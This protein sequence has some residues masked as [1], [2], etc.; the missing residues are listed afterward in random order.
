VSFLRK[1]ADSLKRQ[2]L[3]VDEDLA[4]FRERQGIV[5]LG[6][7]AT[8]EVAQ[9]A[10]LEA[11]RAK[12]EAERA[13]LERLIADGTK[14]TTGTP[15]YRRLTAFPTL[16]GNPVVAQL[17]TTLIQLEDERSDLLL[18]RTAKDP[19]VVA[20]RS[21]IAE[22]D[23]QLR[24]MTLSYLSGLKN[25]VTSYDAALRARRSAS[26]SIPRKAMEEERLSR[27]PK[28]LGDV[29]ALVETKLQE[30]RIAE[31]A[32]DPGVMILDRAT[33]PTDPAW[34]RKGLIL[35]VAV[36]VGLIL[37][38]ALAWIR[39]QSDE[40]IRTRTDVFDIADV[41]VLGFVPHATELRGTDRPNLRR[42]LM[43]RS[44]GAATRSLYAANE[45]YAWLET[46][47]VFSQAGTTLRTLALTSPLARD[48]KTVNA[49]N[50]ATTLAQR[51]RRVLLMDADLRRGR[52]HQVLGL[53]KGPGLAEV[54]RGEVATID[55]VATVPVD[56]G[57]ATVEVLSCGD[58]RE[59]PGELL[60]S[61]AMRELLDRLAPQYDLVIIDTTPVNL[62]SDA[63]FVGRLVDGVVL[64]IRA[65]VTTAAALADAAQHL[66]DSGAPV[67]GVL[68]N[69]V[70]IGR[71][72]SYDEGY[73][74][75]NQAAAYASAGS[76]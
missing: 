1:E 22:V 31:G 2:L 63:L 36:A 68:L 10:E 52:I 72:A 37:G 9:A 20:N 16:I 61:D 34:P 76:R 56:G 65:G 45:A 28:V 5:S 74:Y 62:V 54:L 15:P 12:S 19:D 18:R 8:A 67:L 64:V 51:G 39:D 73:R 24:G 58:C 59:H 66:R 47:L 17:L 50:L 13:A 25:Q 48:G 32:A 38:A 46:S 57:P 40:A 26:A 49:V 53:S 41:P 7:Q 71:D 44:R 14:D 42:R 21:K 4:R 60:R 43:P 35:T 33:I 6:D 70:D 69:D 30:A 3:A 27:R 75:L 55:A 11:A 29:Y 23:Q